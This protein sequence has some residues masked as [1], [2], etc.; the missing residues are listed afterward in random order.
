MY[1]TTA[2]SEVLPEIRKTGSSFIDIWP[3]PHANH[4]EQITMMGLEAFEQLLSEH[5]VK[6]GVLTQYKLG[7]FGPP[8]N[9]PLHAAL[10]AIPSCAG[11]W[12]MVIQL[13][14]P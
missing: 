10:V 5:E 9:S 12:E 2:L 6:L 3:R 1:G 4:R 7:P 14:R 8:A 13:E 11:P